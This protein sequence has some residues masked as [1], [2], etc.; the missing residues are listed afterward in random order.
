MATP[1]DYVVRQ[2]VKINK[3]HEEY[4]GCRRCRQKICD[5]DEIIIFVD[6]HICIH[7]LRG[8]FKESR[9]TGKSKISDVIDLLCI[10][11]D[12]VVGHYLEEFV[13]LDAYLYFTTV[14][15]IKLNLIKTNHFSHQ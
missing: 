14:R 6:N 8:F 11:C 7:Y 2:D 12:N 15:K 13:K 10:Q 3:V 9:K 5:F 4:V 1:I